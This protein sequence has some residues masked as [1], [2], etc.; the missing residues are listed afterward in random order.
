MTLNPFQD[1]MGND[2]HDGLE[3]FLDKFHQPGVPSHTIIT[4]PEY[5]VFLW[6]H[7]AVGE[8]IDC[9]YTNGQNYV[10]R[11]HQNNVNFD[12][13]NSSFQTHTGIQS[14]TTDTSLVKECL[15]LTP[16]VR[17]VQMPEI[18]PANG[19]K[20]QTLFG[21]TTAGSFSPYASDGSRQI[22]LQ[23]LDTE[24]SILDAIFY[25][26][27]KDINSP[28]WYRPD[29]VYSE[30]ATPY[31]MATL[32]VQRPRMRYVSNAKKKDSRTDAEYVY[33]SY[34]F[35]GVKPTSFNSFSPQSAGPNNL[36]RSLTFICDMCLVDLTHDGVGTSLN[37]SNFGGRKS[38]IF[39]QM[40]E[41]Q[42]NDESDSE[43]NDDQSER[44][45]FEKDLD[46]AS[47]EFDKIREDIQDNETD[48]ES[49]EED[50][51]PGEDEEEY[52]P[53]DDDGYN[54]EEDVD[55]YVDE[56]EYDEDAEDLGYDEDY[57]DDEDYTD[58]DFGEYDEPNE[59]SEDMMM[60]QQEDMDVDDY[61]DIESDSDLV[62]DVSEELMDVGQD[63][64][65][66]SSGVGGW[67]ADGISAGMGLVQSAATDAVG[68]AAKIGVEVVGV[69]S[70]LA[71]TAGSTASN[72]A[73]S[74]LNVASS[75]ASGAF[76]LVSGI[77]SSTT[78]MGQTAFGVVA[79]AASSTIGLADKVAQSAVSGVVQ[80]AVSKTTSILGGVLNNG[81]TAAFSTIGNVQAKAGNILGSIMKV[82]VGN[83]TQTTTGG[84][85]QQ[86]QQ[87]NQIRQTNA[88]TQQ[89]GY[90]ASGI[91]MGLR[92]VANVESKLLGV[93]TETA[94]SAIGSI[95]K[96]VGNL[97][98]GILNKPSPVA[99]HAQ[100]VVRNDQAT[101][102]I[103]Q[104][105]DD[106]D[107]G[108]KMEDE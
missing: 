47:S 32:E 60:D 76:G 28:W 64:N 97:G 82:G 61:P 85:G 11:L 86:I 57:P 99:N 48:V 108:I 93:A 78:S 83:S 51:I 104:A 14:G 95:G 98:S 96:L 42:G 75:A 22:T 56:S 26:W 15:D 2:A 89:L 70:S 20:I 23:I 53:P 40:P 79:N 18:A 43:Q 1:P 9:P 17:E 25:P 29:R 107:D 84:V 41:P 50:Y 55:P 24:Y 16:F 12:S 58:E 66:Q 33:Y 27:M 71:S 30:W 68:A 6:F 63:I 35:L 88:L 106:N 8:L 39:S 54:P 100:M 21:E 101:Q 74:A 77:L 4:D 72:V 65:E 94:T 5:Y 102:S 19:E 13:V 90:A 44:D 91:Q 38:F 59:Y 31:P 69:A 87:M 105:F 73:G 80:P 103:N 45:E 52:I 10:S 3:K 62:D 34:K 7:N 67:V 49:E 92:T 46:D 81:L 36:L 37:S